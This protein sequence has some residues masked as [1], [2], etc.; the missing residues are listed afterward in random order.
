ME[1]DKFHFDV[2]FKAIVQN[3]RQDNIL[4]FVRFT[5]SNFYKTPTFLY[6]PGTAK[7]KCCELSN[8]PMH[9]LLFDYRSKKEEGWSKSLLTLVVL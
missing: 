5:Y 9:V 4:G 8:K 7:I 6:L 2:T 1:H 3:I